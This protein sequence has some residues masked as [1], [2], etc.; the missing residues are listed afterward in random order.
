[1]ESPGRRE[2]PFPSWR[3]PGLLLAAMVLLLS[4]F[5]DACEEPPTFEAMELIGKP[6]P[7]YEIG[8]RVDY[9]CK[10]GYFYI[11][12][13][14]THTICDRNHTWL[15]VSDDACYRETCPYIRDPLNGQAIPANGTYEFGYQMHFI[16]NEGYYLIGEEILY[17]ELKGS[18]A[19]W[20]GKP[21]ICEKVLCTP[22]PKIKNGKHTFSEVEVFE[23]LDAVTYSCDPAPGPDPFSLIGE[24]TIYCGDNSVWSRAAPECKVVK[25]RFP[26]VENGKQISGFGKKFYYKATVMFECDKGFYL[27]GSDTIV[28]DSNSTWVPPVPK[29]LKGPRPTYKPPVSNY[30]GYPKPEE[31]ILDSLDVWVIAVIVIAIVVGVAVICVVPYRYLQRRKKKGKADGGAEYATY[32]TKSTTPAEQRG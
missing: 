19:V 4:S 25:C 14:A 10:K 7:Y 32:Q 5:S 16:C 9:K 8:E 17:C 12:P 21:P 15:P 23:Y 6:K 1:M 2:C 28:C 31:G 13:L 18:V 24:S 22:P 29:C 20:S 30:P 3:F 26:V 11:P 27:D